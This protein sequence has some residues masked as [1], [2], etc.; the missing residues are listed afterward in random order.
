MEPIWL[1]LAVL[2]NVSPTL[3]HTRFQNL[4][5]NRV[6]FSAIASS[7]V[8]VRIAGMTLQ[9]RTLSG[10]MNCSELAPQWPALTFRHELSP[11]QSLA[12]A[13]Q[14]IYHPTAAFILIFLN[15]RGSTSLQ[16]GYRLSNLLNDAT[17]SMEQ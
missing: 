1:N 13:Y 14:P 10:I 17:K 11:L 15:G 16:S 9:V 3:V 8:R 5:K 2:E 4:N 12:T 7:G 6:H